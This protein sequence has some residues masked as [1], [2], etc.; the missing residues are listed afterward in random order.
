MLFSKPE[1]FSGF[2]NSPGLLGE[3]PPENLEA[4]LDVFIE[5]WHSAL[6]FLRLFMFAVWRFLYRL[7][8]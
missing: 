4:E 6:L 3:V 5:F 8:S 1:E 7:I 2:V